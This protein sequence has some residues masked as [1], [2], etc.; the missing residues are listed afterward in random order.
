MPPD[1]VA[2]HVL[3]LGAVQLGP[4]SV[5]EVSDLDLEVSLSLDSEED[6]ESLASIGDICEARRSLADCADWLVDC[7][8]GFMARIMPIVTT[9]PATTARLLRK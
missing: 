9:N 1:E 6:S 4:L 2:L 7:S 8:A 3:E 5:E